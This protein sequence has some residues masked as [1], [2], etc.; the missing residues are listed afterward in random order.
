MIDV[1][2]FKPKGLD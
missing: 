1:R 2:N